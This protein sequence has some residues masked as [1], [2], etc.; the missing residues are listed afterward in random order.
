MPLTRGWLRGYNKNRMVF[1][2]AMVTDKGVTVNC[3]ISST[4]MDDLAGMRGT[5]PNEREVQF[6]HYR[7]AIER[8]ASDIF[9]GDTLVQGAVIPGIRQAYSKCTPRLAEGTTTAS[10]FHCA[11]FWRRR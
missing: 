11:N 10:F 2:F 5:H 6:L 8:V 1:E 4:A 7:E 9:D 3:E